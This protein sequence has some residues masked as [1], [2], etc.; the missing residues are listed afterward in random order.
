[1]LA[2][3]DPLRKITKQVCCIR[4]NVTIALKVPQQC[5]TTG[6]RGRPDVTMTVIIGH[7]KVGRG[8]WVACNGVRHTD[9]V[10]GPFPV[11]TW[12]TVFVAVME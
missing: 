8:R 10:L 6:K 4:N 11:L 5:G 1:M 9:Q 7:K 3:G 12:T 2:V